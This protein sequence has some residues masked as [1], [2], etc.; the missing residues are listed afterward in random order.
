[1]YG[2]KP[3]L[4]LAVVALVVMVGGA[5]W[6]QDAADPDL[7][8]DPGL[9]DPVEPLPEPSDVETL[10]QMMEA[11]LFA[12]RAQEICDEYHAGEWVLEPE[13]IDVANRETWYKL[14]RGSQ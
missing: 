5:G 13:G 1:M 8:D 6:S 2:N 11:A 12:G 3:I 14:M 10:E 9:V 4:A 7:M